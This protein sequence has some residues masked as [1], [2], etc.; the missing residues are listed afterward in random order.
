MSFD[1]NFVKAVKQL[2]HPV[3][4]VPDVMLFLTTMVIGIGLFKL[5]GLNQV[6]NS[7]TLAESF[8]ADLFKGMLADRW[9]SLVLGVV[10]F[11][12][13]TFLVG[14]GA[15]VLRFNMIKDLVGGKKPDLLHAWK[16]GK[17]MLWNVVGLK[18]IV[19]LLSLIVLGVMVLLGLVLFWMIG[20]V[21]SSVLWS[22]LVLFGLVLLVL[23]RVFL[24]FRYPIFFLEKSNSPWNVIKGSFDFAKLNLGYAFLTML[25]LALVMVVFGV[26]ALP[27]SIGLEYLQGKLV[28]ASMLFVLFGYLSSFVKA[29]VNLVY[30]LWMHLFVFNCYLD[31]RK[32]H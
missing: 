25:A 22:I 26:V 4:F 20:D 7:M 17:S 11:F 19:Y 32:R 28:V 14:V 1:V 16:A 9:V 30:T 8:Q 10:I 13:A 21:N 29:V 18:V 2:R 24:L 27:V 23:L 31:K 15:D 5:T 12:V 6:I 3:L